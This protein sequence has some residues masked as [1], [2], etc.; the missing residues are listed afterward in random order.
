MNNSLIDD[1][2]NAFTKEGDDLDLEVN[3]L[4]VE[5]ITSK[6][7][8]FNLDSEGNLTVKSIT[9]LDGIPSLSYPVGS[10]YMSVSPTNPSSALGGTW[11]A[12]GAG[13]VPVGVSASGTFNTV[14]KTGGSETHAHTSP[15][16]THASSAHAHDAQGS[17]YAAFNPS[18][19][20]PQ[21]YFNFI[22]NASW[23]SNGRNVVSGKQ[24]TTS[25]GAET[26]GIR[27]YGTTASTT[28]GATGGTAA[29]INAGDSLQP[30]IT[31]YMWKRTA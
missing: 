31:C 8:A 18:F 27:C 23:T 4:N 7:D 19:N 22:T 15:A 6:N 28:P 12:W 26:R 30:Y 20:G 5:C 9:V 21:Q 16:H 17:I 29:T 10:I 13:R 11:V 25:I 3:N 24:D 2:L 1:I 14:E